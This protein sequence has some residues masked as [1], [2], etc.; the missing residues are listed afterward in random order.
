MSKRNTVS[1][2]L[3]YIELVSVTLQR[4]VTDIFVHPSTHFLFYLLPHGLRPFHSI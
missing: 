2:C 4:L 1:I 3:R